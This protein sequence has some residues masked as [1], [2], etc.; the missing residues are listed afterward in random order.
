MAIRILFFRLRLRQLRRCSSARSCMRS[1]LS[2]ASPGQ[3]G[4]TARRRRR[5]GRRLAIDA[6]LLA[7][8]AV[9]HSVMARPWFKRWWTQIVPWAI[10]RS[11][12][13]LF[14]SLALDL[15][16]W[17]WRPLGGARLE[18]RPAALTRRGLDD[19]RGRLAAGARDDVLYQPF[20]SVRTATGVAAPDRTAI[21]ARLLRDAGA[22]SRRP[23]SAVSGFPPRI[24]GGAD[25]DRRAPR[26]CARDDDLHRARDSIRR[27][28][29]WRT[30]T[31]RHTSSIAARCRC[32][33]RPGRTATPKSAERAGHVT[34]A[35]AFGD[36]RATSC[37][38]GR[39][40]IP[41]VPIRR[42]APVE[43]RASRTLTMRTSMRSRA[44]SSSRRK[45]ATSMRS[46][47]RRSPRH[48]DATLIDDRPAAVTSVTASISARVPAHRS[49]R[50]P[51]EV[52][53]VL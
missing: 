15:M 19:L 10:E 43:L 39:S 23:P 28:T 35:R 47:P 45:S 30:S 32:C 11:T 13:V 5:S 25:D 27:D 18:H 2:A 8:F 3:P 17:Q 16:F 1:R 24:L 38:N 42:A 26:V 52:R 53:R 48:G 22:L 50:A 44:R 46:G 34:M 4:W 21:H 51:R 14:A 20:R 29:I 49:G 9:Q 12:Y 7:V 40:D 6:G 31:A 33:C 41:Y 36:R 37:T